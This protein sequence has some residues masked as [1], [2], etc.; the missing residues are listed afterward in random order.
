LAGKNRVPYLDELRSYQPGAA[1]VRSAEAFLHHADAALYEVKR[2]GRDGILLSI[3]TPE[4]R[5]VS[6]WVGRA[7]PRT[8]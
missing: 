5:T 1:D 3:A 2:R 4:P 6:P 7:E 8:A